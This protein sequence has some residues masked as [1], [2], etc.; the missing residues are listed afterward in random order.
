MSKE[1]I[2]RFY[3][4]FAKHDAEGMAACYADDVAFSDPVFPDLKGEEARDMWRMLC[5]RGKD[6]VVEPSAITDNSAHWDA[7]YTFSQTG[8]KV[9][10]RIDAAF[11]V[12][13]G[14][15][16]RHTDVFDLWKW[17]RM[18]LGAPGVFLGWSPMV[19]NKVRG[20]AA[21]A[22]KSYRAKKAA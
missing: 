3:D 7:T 18:A 15:I 4:A 19:Q 11:V 16:K 2:T 10:N 12:E 21:H 8:R 6:L 22:L 5:S 14:K 9:I 13:G 20:Q 1:L 17:T